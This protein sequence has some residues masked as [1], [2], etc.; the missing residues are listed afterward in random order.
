MQSTVVMLYVS[1]K[2]HSNVW[3]I[4]KDHDFSQAEVWV[5]CEA[6]YLGRC[7]YLGSSLCLYCESLSFSAGLAWAC[8]V[9]YWTGMQSWEKQTGHFDCEV[10]CSGLWSRMIQ[11]ASVFTTWVTVRGSLQCSACL[12]PALLASPGTSVALF[13][14]TYK[15]APFSGFCL[16]FVFRNALLWT[17]L[18]IDYFL[19][20]L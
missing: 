4:I 18:F 1:S 19:L 14:L 16:F 6:V 9:C 2:L 3:I 11:L 10:P 5:N 8:G 12:R 15:W 7:A 13:T 17:L 20:F